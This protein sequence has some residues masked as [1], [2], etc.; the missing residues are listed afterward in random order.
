MMKLRFFLCI[1]PL[2][3][4]VSC[5]GILEGGK[6]LKIDM[7]GKISSVAEGL[8]SLGDHHTD[9]PMIHDAFKDPR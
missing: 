5:Y 1:I 7:D 8:P 6:I 4:I 3:F 9:G 2:P